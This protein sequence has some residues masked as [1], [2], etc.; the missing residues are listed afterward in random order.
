MKMIDVKSRFG[1]VIVGR[2]VS[3]LLSSVSIRC[4]ED[5]VYYNVIQW[6]SRSRLS[7]TGKV[8]ASRLLVKSRSRILTEIKTQVIQPLQVE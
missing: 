7:Q 6:M 5:I 2:F 8:S 1:S 4:D 3:S